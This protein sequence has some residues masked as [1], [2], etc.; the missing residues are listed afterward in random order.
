MSW[1]RNPLVRVRKMVWA[2]VCASIV[3]SALVALRGVSDGVVI[4]QVYGG[5]GN[6]GSIYRN[7]FIE[8]Y[9][10]G[11][12]PIDIT[13]WSVQYASATGATWQVTPLTGTI[14]PGRYYLVQE[15]AGT[16]GT[17]SLPAPDATG[18]IA[19]SATAGKV[20]LVTSST[21]LS[22]TCPASGSIVDLVGF[23][24]SSTNCFEGAVLPALG[25]AV[26]AFRMRDASSVEV[27]TDNNLF[28]FATGDARPGSDRW[29]VSEQR[30]RPE[31]SHIAVHR[32]R[33]IIEHV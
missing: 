5:G 9:N 12:T 8:L 11:A 24:G 31:M 17:S 21:A 1:L 16:G 30:P 4:S 33:A 20:A 22:G 2:A 28:D 6:S 19:M 3:G 26:A 27:D 13:G 32:L 18:T 29:L 25:N 15:A 14:A 7:D 10:R 23:G